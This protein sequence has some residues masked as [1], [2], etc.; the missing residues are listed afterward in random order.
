MPRLKDITGQRFG[1]LVAQTRIG[2][3]KHGKSVWQ[4]ICDCGNTHSC[5]LGAVTSGNTRSCGCFHKEIVSEMGKGRRKKVNHHFFS[6]WSEEMAWVLGFWAADGWVSLSRRKY[7]LGFSQSNKSAIQKVKRLISSDHKVS[8]K[9]NGGVSLQYT[10]KRQ[11]VDLCSLF[12]MDVISK[13][14][15]LKWPEI[16]K[17]YIKH[18][19]RGYVDGD[20]CLT[21]TNNNPSL[22]ICSGSGA[23]LEGMGAAIERETGI[24]K[25]KIGEYGIKLLKYCSIRAVCLSSWLYSECTVCLDR[26]KELALEFMKW[27]G[28]SIRRSSLTPK[29][30]EMFPEFIKS[31]T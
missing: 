26:K 29:M 1:R 28:K 5:I 12:Q 7:I 31:K 24:S 14:L 6:K 4:F 2:K 8:T 11:Y 9:D 30:V 17:E 18:F 15:T 3:N 16:P 21:W 10:S 23:F 27:K 13:S 22:S 19:V 25:P 20:G